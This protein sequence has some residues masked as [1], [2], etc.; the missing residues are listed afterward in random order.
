MCEPFRP[1]DRG[2]KADWVFPEKFGNVWT[3]P[4]NYKSKQQLRLFDRSSWQNI[5]KILGRIRY[6]IRAELTVECGTC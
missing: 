3:W 6:L 5:L 2:E 1:P 4:V